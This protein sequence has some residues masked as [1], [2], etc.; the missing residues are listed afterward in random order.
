VS[1]VPLGTL[2]ALGGAFPSS[3]IP[4][5]VGAA[6]AFL[7]S[8]ARIGTGDARWLDLSLLAVAAAVVL[9]LVPLP[10]QLAALLSPQLDPLRSALHLDPGNASATLSVD[11]RMTRAGLATL[12]SMLFV[13]WAA[14]EVFARR[15]VRMAARAIAWGGLA[16]TMVAFAQRATA[17][18]LLLWRWVPVDPGSQPFGP[19]VNRNHL[20]T[21]LLMA[22][23]LAAGYLAAHARSH[24]ARAASM[25]LRFRDWLADGSGLILAGALV[26]MLLGIAATLSR[27]AILGAAAAL[28][29]GVL[30]PRVHTRTR[31]TRMAAAAVAVLLTMAVWSNWEALARKFDSTTTGVGRMTIWQETLPIVR[32]F[33]VAGTGVGTYGATMLHY[34]RAMRDLF[35]N[36]AH[37]EYLQ[38][39][40][41]GGLLL[42]VPC[43]I[44]AAAA[45]RMA[46]RR[47]RD[48]TRALAWLRI[49][50]AAGLAG[51]AVQGLFE[52]G[53]R[54]PANG[55]LAALLAAVLLHEH[56]VSEIAAAVETR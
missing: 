22:S 21:W 40:A 1:A 30:L 37:N 56:R 20:A 28:A 43:V 18:N 7:V 13:F 15:G 52:T 12:A 36:Q 11:P 41:E 26:A 17:P 14:R 24:G 47:L 23:A 42:M 27:A 45:L 34:Q 25:R 33:W 35:F 31:T 53:L 50:A 51:V 5:L 3:T 19:F 48:D 32:D 39:A 44:A 55:L 16:V 38:V 54:I 4:I 46:R 29:A 10:S 2:A 8:R 9:Q 6:L 49:G